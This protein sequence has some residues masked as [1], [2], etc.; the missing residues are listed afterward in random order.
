MHERM[1]EMDVR[2]HQ[3]ENAIAEL[4]KSV[5]SQPHPLLVPDVQIYT[6]STVPTVQRSSND[7]NPFR[8][9]QALDADAE[10]ARA[11]GVMSIFND[12]TQYHGETASS[13][14][15]SLSLICVCCLHRTLLTLVP[16]QG[17]PA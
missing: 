15:C 5:S 6:A 7:E 1:S 16:S 4:Q 12:G 10:L 9:H 11:F 13:E 17:I 2:M 3:L 14:V 8:S